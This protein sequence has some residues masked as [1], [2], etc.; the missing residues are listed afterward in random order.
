MTSRAVTTTTTTNRKETQKETQRRMSP[1][2]EVSCDDLAPVYLFERREI[3]L[4]PYCTGH[5]TRNDAEG[6]KNPQVRVE[7]LTDVRYIDSS[8]E[9]DN[10][11]P[12]KKGKKSDGS[13]SRNVQKKGSKE[14]TKTGKASTS[15]QK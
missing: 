7:K 6:L 10:R 11:R 5:L 8:D 13:E 14:V 9:D 2:R 4:Y 12:P 3:P 15:K 1:R